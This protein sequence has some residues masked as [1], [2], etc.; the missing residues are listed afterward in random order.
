MTDLV[1]THCHLDMLADPQ[2]ALRDA[3]TVGVRTVVTI[4]VDL[5]SSRA[6]VRLAEGRPETGEAPAV[7]A[8]AGLHP[9]DAAK[10]SDG[11]LAEL[12]ELGR[13]PRTVAVGECG[14]DYYRDLSPRE[15]QRDAFLAQI[16]LARRLGLPL[17][18]HTRDAADDTLA[19]LAAEA[20]GLAVILHCFSL[21]DRLDEAV[22]RGYAISFAGNVT[23]KNAAA[24][25]EAA[26]RV[27]DDLLLAETDAP[28]LTPVP[29]RGKQNT[30]ARV[31]LTV[32]ALAEARGWPLERAAEVTTA[33]ARKVFGLTARAHGAP[34]R[35]RGPGQTAP[36]DAA[37]GLG[38]GDA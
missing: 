9:H 34:R 26:A 35:G 6:A 14:L 28:F 37:V 31:A 15:A 19:L 17:V 5:A 4:G 2:A 30:P 27:P 18:V 23:F 20:A 33:N 16:D 21:P 8:T 3:W 12:E 29:Y 7:F 1:D 24:L 36:G 10:L 32:A 11:L 13:R 25:R 22:D 38:H